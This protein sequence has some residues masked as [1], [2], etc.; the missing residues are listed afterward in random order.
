MEFLR[1]RVADR[2]ILRLISKWLRAGVIDEGRLL[3]SEIGTPQGSVI[4]PLLANIYLHYV[5]DEWWHRDVIPRMHGE[6]F[7]IR[8]ADDFVAGFQH[9]RDAERVMVALEKRFE[10]FGLELHKDK[11]RLIPYGQFAELK[12]RQAGRTGSSETFNFLGFTHLCVRNQLGKAVHYVRT[13]AKR[14]RRTVKSIGEWCR[15][16]RH[17]PVRDQQVT[18]AAKLQG[19]YAYYGRRTNIYQLNTVHRAAVRLWH[20]WLGRRSGRDVLTWDAFSSIQAQHPLPPP[21]ITEPIR[22]FAR[23][24]S[25]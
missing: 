17:L 15:R 1:V 19:H 23:P 18:L 2:S 8:Y 10:R 22:Y 9:R 5:L 25:H 14:V 16:N 12:E 3:R 13:M 4:S 21:R 6:A 20:K 11:T 24:Q 7:L